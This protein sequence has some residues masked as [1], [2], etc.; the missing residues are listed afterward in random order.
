MEWFLSLFLEHSALQAVVIVSL[1]SGI[2]LFL[3]KIKVWGISLGVTFVF[4]MGIFMGH[5]GFTIDQQ[6]L[7]FIESFGLVL[8]VYVLGLQV[9]PGFFS[10]FSK[11]GIRLNVFAI[12]VVLIGTLLTVLGSYLFD[13]SLPDMVG[14]LCGATT[15]TPA[16]GA[17]QTT[18]R[19]LGMETATPALGCAVTYPLGVVGVIL[20]I[21]VMQ[22]LFVKKSDLKDAG[23]TEDDTFIGA[24]YVKNPAMFNRKIDELARLTQAKFVIS[25]LWRSGSVSIPTS[26]TVIEEGDRLLVVCTEDDVPRLTILFGTSEPEDLTK[27]DIDWNAIDSQLTSKDIVITRPEINGKRIE[28]LRLRNHYGVNISR[29]HRSGVRLLAT[30]DLMLQLGDR[31]TI[32]GESS[33]IEE[34]AKVLGNAVKQ[35]NEPNLVAIFVG[36]I[37][38]LVLGAIPI[39]V[40][41][42]SM[43]I[44]LGLAGGPIVIGLLIGRFG[45]HFHM[46]TYTTPSANLML[47]TL[48]LTLYLACLGLDS[49]AQFFDTV[50][51]PEGALWVAI[52]FVLT[53]V[54]VLIVGIFVLKTTNIEFGVLAGML[55]GC[56]ANPMAL[57]YANDTIPGDQ[58]AVAYATVYPLSMFLRVIL[59]QVL[60]MLL[61]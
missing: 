2:G 32:V 41:G 5:L 39:F 25:R 28:L 48:G 52:G 8:F 49:G 35:L 53:I 18:L 30:P 56:M 42:I 45:P 50:F 38:G 36:I 29:V 40:P 57:D 22:K 10:S 16:L 26:S 31:V 55:C 20:A 47:R 9:G 3:G 61:L 14:L 23:E 59:A 12:A 11:G 15:N 46:I 24:F 44:K 13:V 4:F 58:P 6:M 34:V 21:I 43:P 51:R 37:L 17:A 1:I 7:N 60:L 54:P 19:E 27:R 33:D